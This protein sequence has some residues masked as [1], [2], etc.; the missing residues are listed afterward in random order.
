MKWK[1]LWVDGQLPT[2]RAVKF[3][4]VS[5]AVAPKHPAP[6]HSGGESLG[7]C[8]E[9]QWVPGNDRPFLYH[10]EVDTPLR[11]NLFPRNGL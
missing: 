6:E 10:L 4:E 7:I 9:T 2:G 3:R 5:E 8:P 11:L 1:S